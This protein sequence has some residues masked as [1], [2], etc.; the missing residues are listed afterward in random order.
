MKSVIFY[1]VLIVLL[2]LSVCAVWPYW[3]RY[4]IKT[5]LE[6]AALYATKHSSDDA[7]K[8]FK[9]KLRESGYDFNPENFNIDKNENNTVSIKWTYQDEISVFGFVLKE[10]EFTLEVTE[11]E[12]EGQY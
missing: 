3:N 10:L 7:L 5:D 9:E 11:R 6:A 2:L 4:L 12:T 1:I 8:L